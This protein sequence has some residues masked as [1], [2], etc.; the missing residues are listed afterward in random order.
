[1][2]FA[3]LLSG[4]L[5]FAQTLSAPSPPQQS[6]AQEVERSV[7]ALAIEAGQKNDITPIPLID[8]QG[9]KRGELFD[10][11]L[12]GAIAAR[13]AIAKGQTPVATANVTPGQGLLPLNV[14]VI[15]RPWTCGDRSVGIDN[16]E[17]APVLSGNANVSRRFM[18]LDGG[19][20][21]GGRVL[22]AAR[23]VSGVRN[24][25]WRDQRERT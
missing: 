8:E 17:L 12:L 4:A 1:M 2:V 9:Q 20:A 5:V 25:A 13:A 19:A 10:R 23:H 22:P 14:V 16:V 18:D 24:R 6:A 7:T 21:R 15:A 11:F 3:S